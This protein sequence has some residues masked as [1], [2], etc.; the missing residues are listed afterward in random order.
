MF[1]A[2]LGFFSHL[3]AEC[4]LMAIIL[5]V[6]FGAFVWRAFKSR[7]V[8]LGSEGEVIKEQLK[9]AE[10]QRDVYQKGYHRLLEYQFEAQSIARTAMGKLGES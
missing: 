5:F 8:W 4:L 10:A 1:D 7:M 6:A 3:G 9:A 2:L